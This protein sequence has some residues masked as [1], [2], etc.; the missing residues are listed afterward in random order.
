MEIAVVVIALNSGSTS[1]RCWNCCVGIVSTGDSIYCAATS[2][3]ILGAAQKYG[4]DLIHPIWSD[5]GIITLKGIPGFCRSMQH[6]FHS[7]PSSQ[8]ILQNPSLIYHFAWNILAN[9]GAWANAWMMRSKTFPIWSIAP[10]G[11]IFYVLL[12]TNGTL[13]CGIS[14]NAK[15]KYNID[16]KALYLWGIDTMGDTLISTGRSSL[17]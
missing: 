8:S 12:F 2:R 10:A 6:K 9:Y 4:A 15:A 5:V 17:I 14:C 13:P 11:A 3:P 16:Q 1:V 7:S